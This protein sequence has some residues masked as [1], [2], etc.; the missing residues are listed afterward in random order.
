MLESRHQTLHGLGRVTVRKNSVSLTSFF[1][2]LECELIDR[3]SFRSKLH[4]SLA[5]IVNS[6]RLLRPS[7]A[8]QSSLDYL[9]PITYESRH[10]DLGLIRKP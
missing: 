3:H 5:V 2:S 4:S 10:S 1:A 9:S 6:G 7:Q 8:D